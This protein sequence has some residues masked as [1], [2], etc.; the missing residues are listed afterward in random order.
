VQRMYKLEKTPGKKD[1][2]VSIP[3]VDGE[4]LELEVMLMSAVRTSRESNATLFV[5]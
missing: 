3:E 1:F 2:Q 4:D 5:L